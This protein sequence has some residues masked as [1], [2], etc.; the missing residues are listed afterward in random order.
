[1]RRRE[2][3]ILG[4]AAAA[5]SGLPLA[6][7][8]QQA[9][10]PVIGF[11]HSGAA[12]ENAERLASFRKSLRG[13]GF[14]EG[15]NVTIEFRW[16]A[17]Q[18]AQ[19]PD[20]AADL[21]RRR[22]DVIVTPASVPAAIAAKAATKDIPIVFAV[23]SDP[24]ALGLVPA[25]NH[26]GGNLTGIATLNAELT[27]KRLGFL[28]DIVP[29]ATRFV[30]L[31]NSNNP[32]AEAVVREMRSSATTFGID[33]EIVRTEGEAGLEEAF[34]KIAQTPG[35]AMVLGTD[36]LFYIRR[37]Q[38]TALAARHSLP[39]V[40]DNRD[41]VLAGGLMSYGPDVARSFEQVAV[42]VARVLKGEKPGELPI[43]QSAKFETVINMKTARALGL[44]I[45]S[46]LLF[47]ADA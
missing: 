25:L 40:Y 11:L 29:K 35:T 31:V 12:E 43:E 41:Y 28:R 10:K 9:A 45:P 15:R 16:A 13:A 36:S 7:R 20:M 24:V 23:A 38:V 8:G 44:D 1:M 17:G 34:A 5:A 27:A 2:F 6:A 26:P 37:S 14:V 47:T 3:M 39:A 22:V 19:L 4:G 46:K 30:A 33:V 18:T 42:Y 21:V 32:L